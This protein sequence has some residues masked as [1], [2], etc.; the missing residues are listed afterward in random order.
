M[1]ISIVPFPCDEAALTEVLEARREQIREGFEPE[2]DDDHT[3]SE[4]AEFASGLIN[5]RIEQFMTPWVAR[6][7]QE[8]MDRLGGDMTGTGHLAYAAAL[9][10]AEIGRRQ[11][12]VAARTTNPGVVGGAPNV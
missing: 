6:R 8:A 12:L 11:R 10:V 9:L 3:D 2:H 1:A 4:L 5:G 7:L